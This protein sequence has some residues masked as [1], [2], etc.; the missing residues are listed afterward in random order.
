MFDD[1]SAFL[2]DIAKQILIVQFSMAFCTRCS[3]S[4]FST[5]SFYVY[6]WDF[7]DYIRPCHPNGR[8]YAIVAKP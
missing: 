8:N 2:I 4:L 1:Q 5:V 7:V 3:L 6:Y